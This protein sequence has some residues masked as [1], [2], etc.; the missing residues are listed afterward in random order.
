MAAEQAVKGDDERILF[1]AVKFIRNIQ[2]EG[3]I[4]LGGGKVVGAGL[5][6]ARAGRWG[7]R[8][9]SGHPAGEQGN[10]KAKLHG[11]T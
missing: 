11:A 4:F 3:K 8:S 9:R 10:G 2:A 5:D 1:L 6:D 7:W